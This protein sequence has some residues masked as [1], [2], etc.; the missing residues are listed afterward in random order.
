MNLFELLN[1]SDSIEP[2]KKSGSGPGK[3]KCPCGLYLGV[4]TKICKSCGHDFSTGKKV[5]IPEFILPPPVYVYEHLR[6]DTWEK[7]Q[8]DKILA[9]KET[10]A[11]KQNEFHYAPTTWRPLCYSIEEVLS[12]RGLPYNSGI[13]LKDDLNRII[14]KC[15]KT[16]KF[17]QSTDP[18]SG[19][20]QE[21]IVVGVEENI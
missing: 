2:E 1:R 7:E 4:R 15:I 19:L 21:L 3:K 16:D 6:T 11:E 8:A 18:R 13:T 20:L 5:E 14:I 12:R 10:L 17:F 9:R